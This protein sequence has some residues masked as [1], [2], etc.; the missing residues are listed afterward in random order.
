M[1]PLHLEYR[2]RTFDE[3]IGN[4]TLVKNI[5]SVLN[6]TQTFMLHGMRGC[7]KTTL[8]RLIAK[9]LKIHD[10]DIYEIDAAD[11]TSVD[12]ARHLK[13]TAYLSPL[14]GKNKIYIIDECHRLSSNAMDSLLKVFEEPPKSCYFV[15]CTTDPNKVT[16][17]IKSRCKSYEVKPLNYD[18]S[19]EL[20]D[21]ICGEEKIDLSQAIKELIVD[22]C[23]G[24]PR[25]I[26]VAIDM[27]RD[28]SDI[29][30]ASQLLM[31]GKTDPKIIDLCRML[32]K[33]DKWVNIAPIL[34]DIKEEPESIRYAILGYM[35]SVLLNGNNTQAPV[36]ISCFAESFIYS[37]RAGLIL[38]CYQSVL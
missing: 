23:N 34:K 13:S 8:A 5:K 24:I 10:M 1:K 26:V 19:C 12:D 37:K 27:L 3:Y 28:I 15:L 14:A 21:W 11:K 18:A 16:E 2:P 32:L 17:T 36:V 9:E 6:R 22:E 38:A 31:T 20:I 33:R 30:E 4:P 35:S 25:E 7:G 29:E